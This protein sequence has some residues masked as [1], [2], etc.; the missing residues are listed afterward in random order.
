MNFGSAQAAGRRK[1]RAIHRLFGLL[2]ICTGVVV[3]LSVRLS[4]DTVN[5][6]GLWTGLFASGDINPHDCEDAKWRWWFDGQI[7]LFDDNDGF[8]QSLVRP[9]V[10]YKLTDKLTLW[11]G[12]AWICTEPNPSPATDEQRLWQQFT[13]THKFDPT[14]LDVRSRFEQRFLDTGDDTGLRFRQQFALRR[15]MGFAPNF[16]WVAWDEFFFHLNDTDW[17]ANAGF[18]QNRAFLGVGWKPSPEHAWRIETGYLNQFIDR[19]GGADNVS[20]HLMS[21]NLIWNP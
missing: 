19:S 5:D 20:N 14:T 13:W 2:V 12:Y 8:G 21:V 4:A 10:G 16:T 18:D 7:R 3:T 6:D 9:G 17:G 15:P 11:A 1:M